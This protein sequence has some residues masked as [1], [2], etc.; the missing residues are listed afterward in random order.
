M[1]TD[2]KITNTSPQMP[3]AGQT[4]NDLT[5]V[6]EV[7]HQAPALRMFS[8]SDGLTAPPAGGMTLTAWIEG[9]RSGRWRLGVLRVRAAKGAQRDSE[10]IKLTAAYPALHM[11]NSRTKTLTGNEVYTG[12]VVLD[13]DAKDN[14]PEFIDLLSPLLNADQFCLAY[15]RSASGTGLAVYY[16]VNST[17]TEH[18]AA[19]KQLASRLADLFG[20]EYNCVL[21]ADPQ[22]TN[23]N[24]AR[25]TS[26]DPEAYLNKHAECWEIEE[27]PAELPREP[28][29]HIALTG[30]EGQGIVA[31]AVQAGVDLTQEYED[32]FRLG[33]W[34]AQT[35]DEEGRE[36]FHQAS[37]FHP[38]YSTRE[39][40]RKYDACLSDFNRSGKGVNENTPRFLAAKYAPELLE[41]VR[42]NL[43]TKE[44]KNSGK[45]TASGSVSTGASIVTKAP[46][47]RQGGIVSVALELGANEPLRA[48]TTTQTTYDPSKYKKTPENEEKRAQALRALLASTLYKHDPNYM[49]PDPVMRVNGQRFATAGNFSVLVGIQKSGKGFV[50]SAIVAAYLRGSALAFEAKPI[51]GK[52]DVVLV[53]T[54]QDE[55]D[56]HTTTERLRRALNEDQ[57]RR[58]TVYKWKGQ[59]PN[60]TLAMLPEVVAR[61]PS[62]GLIVVDGIADLS[63]QGVNDD[64][65][66]REVATQ[67]AS[68]TAKSGI[69]VVTVIHLN[70]A[71][72][73]DVK[74]GEEFSDR[75][76]MSVAGHLGVN[77]QRK[78]ETVLGV[79]KPIDGGGR[80]EVHPID[81]R[82]KDFTPFG[83]TIHR[84][85]DMPE[86]IASADLEAI[87]V[88]NA[89]AK[90]MRPSE[91]DNSTHTE[92]VAS[93]F[94]HAP[95]PI[96][97]STQEVNDHT[98]RVL[99]KHL[100]QHIGRQYAEDWR[101]HWEAEQLIERVEKAKHPRQ[102]WRPVSWASEPVVTAVVE[103]VPEVDLFGHEAAKDSKP[104]RPKAPR[105]AGR[106]KR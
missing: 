101:T 106:S 75:A 46:E 20:R 94:E 23:A 99:S 55:I 19:Y 82:G 42:V 103:A 2:T 38:K 88:S 72:L 15:H 59:A 102:R 71:A 51:D 10:K 96:G 44:V 83:F 68:L 39:T 58:V 28:R 105:K 14:I 16:H 11:R 85:L 76:R 87:Q 3:P 49:P 60:D 65:G 40:D 104:K 91:V 100:S 29:M 22:C 5:K 30:D 97:Y 73:K 92:L 9:I 41:A 18:K 69:H 81:V 35:Y 52:G 21:V 45:T 78:A 43:M 62:A 7:A 98:R 25:L 53:D 77:L 32:W 12:I 47:T 26:Y 66:A 86:L 1:Q 95:R 27:V 67:L 56:L 79:W 36:F 13:F 70:K 4:P 31:A 37:Q 89:Q 93:V 8:T 57:F 34:F 33:K 17:V 80:R 6:A 50:V 90:N 84:A 63:P 64:I 61:H 24:R 74:T 54:E 48:T